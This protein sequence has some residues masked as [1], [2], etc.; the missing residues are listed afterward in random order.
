MKQQFNSLQFIMN[1]AIMF[2]F[3]ELA[4][5]GNKPTRKQLELKLIQS[6]TDIEQPNITIKAEPL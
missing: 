3:L 6:K 4:G 2:S 5:P 1:I